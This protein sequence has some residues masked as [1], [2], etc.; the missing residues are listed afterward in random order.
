MIEW[1]LEFDFRVFTLINGVWTN[2]VLDFV[3]PLIRNKLFWLPFYVFMIAFFV[4]NFKWQ[5]IY[6]F[7]AIFIVILLSDQLSA[8]FFKPMFERLRPCRNHLLADQ[9]RILVHCG[10]GMSFP[11]SHATNHF[12]LSVFIGILMHKRIPFIVPLMLFWAFSISYAQVYVGVHYPLDITAGAILGTVIG[13]FPA[14]LCK[15]MIKL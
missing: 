13:V 10:A 2:S 11:S 5:S 14:V 8:H 9:I 6:V 15:K 3:L 7:I 4:V 1:L 12:A